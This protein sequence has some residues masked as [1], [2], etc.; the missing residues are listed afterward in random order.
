MKKITVTLLLIGLVNFCKAQD[1][2][3][4]DINLRSVLVSAAPNNATATNLAG[5]NFRIDSNFDNIIQVSEALQ[6]KELNLENSFLRSLDG[7]ENFQ[8]LTLLNF[9][10]NLVTSFDATSFINLE[11]LICTQNRL[12][13]LNVTGLGTLINLDCWS[14][15]LTSINLTGL[16]HL[17]TLKIFINPFTEHIDLSQLHTLKTL[18]CSNITAPSISFPVLGNLEYLYCI[19]T[20]FTTLD[21]S[22]LPQLDY[23]N[24]S[25][26]PSLRTIYR[27]RTRPNAFDISND[28]ALEY[29]CCDADI[30]PWL[31]VLSD[32][33]Q[34]SHFI[35]DS[36]CVN[37]AVDDSEKKSSIVMFPNPATC[38]F[39][40]QTQ[41]E[42]FRT[43]IFDINGRL[44]KTS[45]KTE[46][47]ISNL[48][49]GIYIIKA[50]TNDEVIQSKLIKQ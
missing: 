13:T 21:I 1:I 31:Q 9:D 47:D 33:G 49:N 50:Y 23:A 45:I 4:S 37:L 12:A 22:N 24:L 5:E 43:D 20:S 19:N 26:N 14:N 28:A 16:D 17:E 48:S 7:L 36:N 44:V 30:V 10:R 18:T 42:I 29:I 25:Q 39:N 8:N 32:L 2:I 46:I 6:V 27:K 38:I 15:Q 41:K 35:V 40:I 3:F 34:P 11:T